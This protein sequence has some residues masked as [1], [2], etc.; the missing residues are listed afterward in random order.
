MI[1]R[2]TTNNLVKKW[3]CT[4]LCVVCEWENAFIYPD[5]VWQP[6]R[7]EKNGTSLFKQLKQDHIVWM[8]IFLIRKW[9]FDFDASE[10]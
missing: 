1:T 2:C 4:F 6:K 7:E 8:R 9:F 3:R 10:H 5:V